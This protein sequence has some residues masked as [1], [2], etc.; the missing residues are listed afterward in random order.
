LFITW[1]VDRRTEL[2][3]G[4]QE[5]LHYLAELLQR[6]RQQHLFDVDLSSG[7]FSRVD[8]CFNSLERVLGE[9]IGQLA[10]RKLA[11]AQ[12]E[13]D[14]LGEEARLDD[15]GRQEKAEQTRRQLADWDGIGSRLEEIRKELGELER[16]QASVQ[17]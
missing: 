16:G 10:S 15:K 12:A 13:S 1:Y 14:R 5:L 6:L 4:K 8:E 11:E 17:P 9:Q 7:R 3:A 2:R